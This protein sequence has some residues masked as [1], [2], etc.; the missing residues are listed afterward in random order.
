[1]IKALIFTVLSAGIF[2]AFGFLSIYIL[3]KIDKRRKK[4][5]FD[6]ELTAKQLSNARRLASN[7]IYG[8]TS[9]RFDNS[10]GGVHRK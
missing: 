7:S 5:I 2:C 1:M 3:Y 10:V 6:D 4:K 9:A 8:L